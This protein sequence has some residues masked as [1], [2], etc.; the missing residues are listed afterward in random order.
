[1]I[2]TV[3]ILRRTLW[4]EMDEEEEGWLIQEEPGDTRN[5]GPQSAACGE[6]R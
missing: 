2:I 4:K 3:P 1:M 5:R 6:E